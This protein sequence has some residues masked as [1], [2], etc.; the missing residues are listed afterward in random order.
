MSP[1]ISVVMSAYNSAD[2]IGRAITSILNQSFTDFELIILNDG[3]TDETEVNVQSFTDERIRYFRLDHAGLPSALNYGVSKARADLVARHDS[4]DWSDPERLE[5]Q[6]QRL[7]ADEG[8]AL[9]ASWH[10]VTDA[11]GTLLG[12]KTTAEDDKSLKR[13][14]TRRSPF[15]H[16]AVLMR[17]SALDQV[18]GYNEGMLYSQDYDL[19]LRMAAAN[20]R[21][22]CIPSALYNYSISPESIAKGWYKLGTAE[23]IRTNALRHNN[24][25]SFAAAVIP[26]IGKRR[27][28]ALWHYALG[29]LALE[30]GKQ[31]RAIAS[32]MK[33]LIN[34]P[35]F[36]HAYVKLGISTLPAFIASRV[37]SR[38]REQR[39]SGKQA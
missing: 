16:G 35:I 20:L 3:S 26:P 8:L 13:M 37:F 34:D 18:G 19:W 31:G 7:N 12:L 2:L 36:G 6:Y 10:N 4:D 28:Q 30:N 22:A 25:E 17:K 29:S 39:E 21:F 5:R 9:V 27:T 15:C 1:K 24:S 33:S 14:L 11:D 38:V 32:F 23:A